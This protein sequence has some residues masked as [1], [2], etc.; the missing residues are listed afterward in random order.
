MVDR[1]SSEGRGSE[2]ATKTIHDDGGQRAELWGK[3]AERW[4]CQHGASS[5]RRS[6]QGQFLWLMD[7]Q[8]VSKHSRGQVRV[9]E[10]RGVRRKEERRSDGSSR[11]RTKTD[12]PG[13][14]ARLIRFVLAGFTVLY[15]LHFTR[16]LLPSRKSRRA[17]RENGR[18]RLSAR[19]NKINRPLSTAPLIATSQPA[20]P[21]RPYGP[22]RPPRSSRPPKRGPCSPSW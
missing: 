17:S 16:K 18:N 15:Q 1:R 19:L 4:R 5:D 12:G 13:V 6:E 10:E 9:R 3:L 2:N 11:T 8:Q 21:P 20:T 22:S 14:S 7:R